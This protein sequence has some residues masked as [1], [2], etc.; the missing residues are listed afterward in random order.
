[1][2]QT[3]QGEKD[4]LYLP[5]NLENC[6]AE[7]SAAQQEL[8][9]MKDKYLRAAAQVENVRKWTERDTLARAKEKQRSFLRQ[10]LEVMDNLERALAQPGEPATLYQGVQLTRNQFGK[11]LAQAGV[12]WIRVEP[13]QAFDPNYHEGVEVRFGDVD[14]PTIAAVTQPGYLYENDLLRPAG[15]VVIRPID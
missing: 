6:H 5:D 4:E 10:L 15:V 1:M 9:E 12:E 7:L 13:G 14:Q 3:E 2:A 8:E 11:V